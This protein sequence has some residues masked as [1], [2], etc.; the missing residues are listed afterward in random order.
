ML[1]EV[2]T[3]RIARAA[4]SVVPQGYLGYADTPM[5]PYDPKKAKALLKE[6]GYP[7]G[8]KLHVVQTSLGVMRDRNNFV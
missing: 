4:K 2:I 6:A 5:L 3:E 8:I 1:Y 7:D